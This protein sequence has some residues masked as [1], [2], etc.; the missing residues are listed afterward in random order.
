MEECVRRNE[1]EGKEINPVTCNFVKKCKPGEFRNELGRCI[2]GKSKTNPQNKTQNK[3]NA[4]PFAP[5]VY[6]RP[7][8]V[9]KKTTFTRKKA[10][11]IPR[12]NGNNYTYNIGRPGRVTKTAKLYTNHPLNTTTTIGRKTRNSLNLE[13]AKRGIVFEGKTRKS[14][15]GPETLNELEDEL[16]E[17]VEG[18]ETT[19]LKE[20][21]EIKQQL[22]EIDPANDRKLIIRKRE[23][24]TR[25][26]KETLSKLEIT[27]PNTEL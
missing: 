26:L 15:K 13:R 8:E 19:L 17:L 18:N 3:P 9:K 16:N 23:E 1:E 27:D 24:L 22:K 5:F 25:R 11:T 6:T 10:K 2:K 4:V 20:L 21:S 12:K 14:K 7:L